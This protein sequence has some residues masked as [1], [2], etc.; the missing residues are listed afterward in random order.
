MI[1]K[2]I[3]LERVL[4][5]NTGRAVIIPMDHGFTVGPIKGLFDMKKT[6]DLIA[7]GGANGII[8]HKGVVM[9]GHRRQGKDVG[10]ILHLSGS[11]S[12]SKDPNAKVLVCS[13]E[14][15]IV[16]GADCVSIHI[17]IGA[18][19]ETKMLEDFGLVS[20]QCN[21]WGIP[22]L[23]MMYTRGE[24]IKSETDAEVVK[25]AARVAAEMGADIVK[26][27]YTGST[28]SFKKVVKGCPIPV[29]IAGGDIF[30]TDEEFLEVVQSAIKAGASGVTIGRNAFAHKTP[31]KMVKAIC[32]IVH[33]NK[34]TKEALKIL[35]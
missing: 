5:R 34:T 31:D 22:L 30:S 21:R 14:E 18:D 15:A 7:D 19:T 9:N 29:M 2:Q 26:V 25:H 4:N 13:V 20:K 16:L 1:G 28:A 6:I 33:E 23:A 10:L 32:S 35:N 8:V 11:T 17:N 3:R 24:H 12:I 27:S